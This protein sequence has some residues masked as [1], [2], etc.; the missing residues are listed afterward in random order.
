MKF[1][2]WVYNWI[3]PDFKIPFSPWKTVHKE[4]VELQLE[5]NG[6]PIGLLWIGD[7]I[8][9]ENEITGKQRGMFEDKM[10]NYKEIENVEALL[11]N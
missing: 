2:Q 3:G 9:Q 5:T 1:T 6:E 10:G 7:V 11:Q 8:I 4:E